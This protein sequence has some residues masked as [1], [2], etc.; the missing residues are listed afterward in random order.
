MNVRSSAT[1]CCCVVAGAPRRSSSSSTF[2]KAL[3]SFAGS[4]GD[5]IRLRGHRHGSANRS[6][7]NGI[8]AL[9][10]L[11][12]GLP[13]QAP[14]RRRFH[15]RQHSPLPSSALFSNGGAGDSVP[16]EAK[17][18]DETRMAR[19]RSGGGSL[20]TR[21]KEATG[22]SLKP[23][24]TTTSRR[25][26]SKAVEA[27]TSTRQSKRT[28]KVGI[29]EKETAQAAKKTS[30]TPTAAPKKTELSRS[31][32]L[33]SSA[34]TATAATTTSSS[35][36]SASFSTS[37]LSSK[38]YS[39]CLPRTRELQVLQEEGRFR[40][41]VGVDEAGRGP[42]AGPVVAAAAIVPSDVD[43][44]ADSKKLTNED[45]REELFERIVSSPGVRWAAAVVDAP[46]IDEI[47]ILQATMRGMSMATEAV[48]R[49]VAAL[50][51]T[52][53]SPST[54]QKRNPDL[55]SDVGTQRSYPPIVFQSEARSSH[56]GCYVVCGFTDADGN[57]TVGLP[58]TGSAGA[59][60][61]PSS[62]VDSV[63]QSYALVDG[64]RLPKDMPCKAEPIVK[65]DSKEYSIAA[66]S[67]VAKVTRDRLMREYA[68]LYPQ[69]SLQQHK[70]YPT[71]AHVAAIHQH[72]ATEIHRRTFAPLK[73]M[74]FDDNGR[75]TAAAES[76]TNEQ[77][78]KMKKK[79][80]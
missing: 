35:S 4:G 63:S 41:I 24:A 59:H 20:S 17:E 31:V 68:V 21:R 36:G 8:N 2:A 52:A 58:S 65:G 7:G 77:Q 44:V 46:T 80:S 26:K 29:D 53:S 23:T 14:Y 19:T 22:E 28:R 79:K 42:L 69:Y 49:M 12:A 54:S 71:S 13:G 70:G 78:P 18:I 67:I 73:H 72:G 11:P 40:A 48:I 75:V 64:N 33:S 56:T 51:T 55:G 15:H 9:L 50:A 74:N 32:S 38:V 61:L 5:P 1:W 30:V 16:A 47:N 45:D 3:L 57:P 10:L 6:I 76:A 39:G 27:A 25:R 34:S 66:A 60:Q 43:G 62:F 37:A